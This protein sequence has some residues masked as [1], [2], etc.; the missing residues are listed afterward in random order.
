MDKK[1]PLFQAVFHLFIRG[2]RKYG[3]AGEKGTDLGL[4]LTKDLYS[5]HAGD[6]QVPLASRAKALSLFL[7]LPMAYG[8]H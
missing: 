2:K 1:Q 4:Q 3:T 6:I 5:E 7:S 8:P